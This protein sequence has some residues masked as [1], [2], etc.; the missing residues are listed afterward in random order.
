MQQK[1]YLPYLVLLQH[2][3]TTGKDISAF[4]FIKTQKHFCRLM[5]SS[6][7]RTVVRLRKEF[8]KQQDY[9]RTFL[10]PYLFQL[11]KK[12]QGKFD[13]EQ[14]KKIR[15]YYGLFIPTILCSS[16]KHLYNEEYTEAERERATLFGVLTPVGDDLFDIDKLSVE[17]IN[18]ITYEPENY[19]ANTFSAQIAKEIHYFL[20]LHSIEDL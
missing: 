11:E 7:I 6:Y 19:E 17:A 2:T 10:N 13:D 15:Q 16:Y 3:R 5:L 14:L 1:A 4:I 12:F 18:K 8:K 20:K 9:I